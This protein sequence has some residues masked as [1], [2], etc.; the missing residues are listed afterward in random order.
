MSLPDHLRLFD[1]LG[2]D[3]GAAELTD[4]GG[5]YVE[6]PPPPQESRTRRAIR[7]ARVALLFGDAGDDAPD[8]EARR[9]AREYFDDL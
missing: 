2:D 1:Q 4:S 6:P 9:L 8:A 5:G 7:G 3:P